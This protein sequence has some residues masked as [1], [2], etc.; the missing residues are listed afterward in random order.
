MKYSSLQLNP[1]TL[2]NTTAASQ[3]PMSSRSYYPTGE[4]KLGAIFTEGLGGA[5]FKKEA[6]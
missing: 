2:N 6:N 4:G 5:K 1:D 3:S